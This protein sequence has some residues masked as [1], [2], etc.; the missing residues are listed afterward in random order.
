VFGV[1]GSSS[2]GVLGHI[3]P[4]SSDCMKVWSKNFNMIVQ[5]FENTIQGQFYGHTHADEFEVFYD[6]EENSKRVK[7]RRRLRGGKKSFKFTGR[8]VGVAYL[9]PSVTTYENHNPAYRIYYVDGDHDN[10]T[11]VEKQLSAW[12]QLI[13]TRCCRRCWT[14]RPGR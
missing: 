7:W 4:G 6:V 1:W 5:R 12:D 14:T 2:G 10:T 8:P 11:R 3:P 9:G 13:R